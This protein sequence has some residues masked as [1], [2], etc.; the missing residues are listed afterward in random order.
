MTVET[1]HNRL[2]QEVFHI[3]WLCLNVRDILGECPSANMSRETQC[4]LAKGNQGKNL[5]QQEHE[6][7]YPRKETVVKGRSQFLGIEMP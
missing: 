2:A 4:L 5:Q 7:C 6:G 1:L 3:S